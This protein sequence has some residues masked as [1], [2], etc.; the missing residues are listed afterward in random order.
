MFLSTFETYSKKATVY[1]QDKLNTHLLGK[2]LSIVPF[3]AL[4]V[5][6]HLLEK[7]ILSLTNKLTSNNL[8]E[9][10]GQGSCTWWRQ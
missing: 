1:V 3:E 6:S 8:E 5:C 10:R 4:E 9:V 7:M 2:A